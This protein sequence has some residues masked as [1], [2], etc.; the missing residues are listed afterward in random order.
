MKPHRILKENKRIGNS[1]GK[2]D[3][4]PAQIDIDLKEK[5]NKQ[6]L[7]KKES[8]VLIKNHLLRQVKYQ[9]DEIRYMSPETKKDLFLCALREVLKDLC[10][11]I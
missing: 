5:R 1:G 3:F 9:T 2:Y 11:E 6:E 4:N 10:L 8:F 7:F